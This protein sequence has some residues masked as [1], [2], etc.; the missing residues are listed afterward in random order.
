M[1]L[2]I[3]RGIIEGVVWEGPPSHGGEI[4]NFLA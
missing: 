2:K 3:S 1:E 4:L